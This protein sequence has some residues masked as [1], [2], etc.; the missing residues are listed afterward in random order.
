MKYYLATVN[1][2]IGEYD[3]TTSIRFA[4][5]QDPSEVHNHI[6]KDWWGKPDKIDD[7]TYYFFGGEV[8]VTA[9]E[10]IEVSREVFES[11]PNSI[12]CSF[13]VRA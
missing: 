11:I 6:V 7:D 13:Y 2:T 3:A 1:M 5:D 10:Q 4:T 9:G 12:A 8:A